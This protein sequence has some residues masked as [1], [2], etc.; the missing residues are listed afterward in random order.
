MAMT[1]WPTRRR[2]GISQAGEGQARGVHPDH[3]QVGGRVGADDLGRQGP[4]VLQGGLEELG[5]GHHVVVGQDVAV[6]GDDDPGAG[7]GLLRRLAGRLHPDGDAHHRRPHLLH[8]LDDGPGIGVQEFQI[9][10]LQG[11]GLAAVMVAGGQRFPGDEFQ[12]AS[13]LLF[14][15]KL[16]IYLET[17]YSNGSI[18]LGGLSIAIYN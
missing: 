9:R 5:V 18:V 2:R 1:S 15:A 12:G 14:H 16:Q 7:P 11:A 8:H 13:Y 4:A 10:G 17:T 6:R 3:R